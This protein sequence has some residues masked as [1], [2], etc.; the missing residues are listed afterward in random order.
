[1]FSGKFLLFFFLASDKW[2]WWW[3]WQ[4]ESVFFSEREI[5]LKFSRNFPGKNNC[6][7]FSLWIFFV[8]V[9]NG[10]FLPEIKSYVTRDS[11]KKNLHY[12]NWIFFFKFFNL[13]KWF[14]FN[15]IKQSSRT[16]SSFFCILITE[17]YFPEIFREKICSRRT[18]L[19]KLSIDFFF[20]KFFLFLF[21]RKFSY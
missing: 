3:W 15:S 21:W 7:Y 16:S 5:N 4:V 13:C 8:V 11:K 1:M 14:F 2:W 20:L 6:I 12:L 17:S 9:E 19:T 10:F 18:F